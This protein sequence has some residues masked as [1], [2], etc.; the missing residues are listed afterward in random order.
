MVLG[1]AFLIFGTA[2]QASLGVI[3]YQM[4]FHFVS[5]VPSLVRVS[6]HC[7]YMSIVGNGLCTLS[8]DVA[9]VRKGVL[10]VH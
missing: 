3:S 4:S 9:I 1:Q 10:S 2:R 8:V 5:H 7:L 6:V